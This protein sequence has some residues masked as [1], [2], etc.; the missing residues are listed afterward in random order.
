M[1]RNPAG[2][3]V[4]LIVFFIAAGARAE[5]RQA[6]GSPGEIC[7]LLVGDTIPQMTLETVEGDSFDLNTAVKEKPTVLIFYRGGW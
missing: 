5:G 4:I 7:P 2:L 6:A 3:F 1:P